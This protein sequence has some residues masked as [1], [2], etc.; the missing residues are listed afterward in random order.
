MFQTVLLFYNCVDNIQDFPLSMWHTP[1][2]SADLVGLSILGVVTEE[3]DDYKLQQSSVHRKTVASRLAVT[4]AR[5]ASSASSQEDLLGNKQPPLQ[6][7][8]RN[9]IVFIYLHAAAL[10][11]FY[12]CFTAAKLATL[13]W[14]EFLLIGH[15]L[16]SVQVYSD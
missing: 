6:I 8:W 1:D 9:V 10:Y 3:D 12:L 14:S 16:L 11:G 15:V 5:N 4:G 2:P 7:V 13:A